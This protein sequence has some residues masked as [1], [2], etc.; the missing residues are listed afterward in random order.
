[1]SPHHPGYDPSLGHSLTTRPVP[2]LASDKD[3]ARAAP[4]C[5]EV[6]GFQTFTGQ[7]PTLDN[8]LAMAPLWVSSGYLCCKR[9]V[10]TRCASGNI[11]L[12]YVCLEE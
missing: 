12:A 4:L 3:K 7:N 10:V 11:L 8:A 6:Y 9:H 5:S 1:M 2:R